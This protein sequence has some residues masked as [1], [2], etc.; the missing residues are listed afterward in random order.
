MSPHACAVLRR[1]IVTGLVV[2]FIGMA[3]SVAGTWGRSGA[4]ADQSWPGSGPEEQTVRGSALPVTL[5]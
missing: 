5:I 3:I 4:P 2:A 1:W